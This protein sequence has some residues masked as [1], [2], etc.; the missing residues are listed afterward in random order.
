[1]PA[2]ARMVLLVGGTAMVF[3]GL[4]A[5]VLGLVAGGWIRAQLPQVVID[6]SAVGG[7]TF[8]LGVVVAAAG[9]IQLLVAASLRLAGRWLMAGAAILAGLLASLL[10][11][12]AVAAATEVARGGTQWLLAGSLGLV[13][14]AVAYGAGAW[15]LA[16][17]S[18]EPPAQG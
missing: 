16:R 10:L 15:Q 1:V 14:A 13:A 12:S 6:A 3:A 9:A 5:A 2:L 17:A 8:A 11:A 18:A 7:A 4:A